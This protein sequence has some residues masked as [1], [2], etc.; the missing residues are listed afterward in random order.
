M[1][2]NPWKISNTLSEIE[3][4]YR[5]EMKVTTIDPCETCGS[6]DCWD[7][8]MDTKWVPYPFARS[9]LSQMTNDGYILSKINDKEVL[10]RVISNS[11]AHSELLANIEDIKGYL[12]E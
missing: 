10:I 7:S 9:L 6:T 5:M 8:L 4:H 3:K 1:S 11:L 2:N 12:S